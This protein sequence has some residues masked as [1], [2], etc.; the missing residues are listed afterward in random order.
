MEGVFYRNPFV[1]K[2]I[3]VLPRRGKS[4]GDRVVILASQRVDI[5][6][7][8]EGVRGVDR[9]TIFP[10]A[11]VAYAFNQ[12]QRGDGIKFGFRIGGIKVVF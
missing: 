11:G 2:I 5:R 10:G 4:F 6:I 8:K 7:Q 9:N 12:I 1:F 3:A